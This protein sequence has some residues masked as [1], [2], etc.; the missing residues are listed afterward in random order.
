MRCPDHRN[1]WSAFDGRSAQLHRDLHES[2]ALLFP[3]YGYFTDSSR[4]PRLMNGSNRMRFTQ[5]A[6]YTHGSVQARH[7]N[8]RQMLSSSPTPYSGVVLIALE[9]TSKITR[10]STK[11]RRERPHG[12]A[13]IGDSASQLSHYA[14]LTWRF[15]ARHQFPLCKRGFGVGFCRTN[16]SEP[17]IRVAVGR[18]D[19]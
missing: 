18:F 4:L 6:L 19:D 8:R 13:R 11:A 5:V 14:I 2:E 10:C 15:H 12:R 1:H 7:T 16:R 9:S 17:T 3:Y